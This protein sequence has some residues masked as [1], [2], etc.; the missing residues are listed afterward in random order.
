MLPAAGE[1]DELIAVRQ[2]LPN[3]TMS[4]RAK[5]HDTYGG[6]TQQEDNAVKARHLA[7]LAAAAALACSNPKDATKPNFFKAL[8]AYHDE[9]KACLR[10]DVRF[11][12]EAERG[13]STLPVL[14]EL[15][16]QGL[17][18]ASDT[19]K[20]V[21]QVALFGAPP[22]RK[23]DATAFALSDTGKAVSREE[24]GWTHS[25][26]FCFGTP[27]VVEVT[28]FT[29]PA[30]MMGVR[31]SQV[32]YTYQVNDVADWADSETLRKHSPELARAVA[33]KETPAQN[34]AALVLMNDGWVHE[35]VAKHRR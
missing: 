21:Q 8:Q 34:K 5:R 24:T 15:A 4:W 9:A 11:P 13:S 31:I 33:S 20:V 27:K 22:T 28:S 18:A 23:V 17:L 26:A 35:E 30:D 32:T 29:E 14:Q 6:G 2:L 7:L 25:T 10:V 16:A 19:K 3:A 12:Y 1:I